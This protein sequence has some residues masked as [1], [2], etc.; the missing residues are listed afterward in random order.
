MRIS[1]VIPVYNGKKYLLAAVNSVIKQTL[2][3]IELIIVDDGS[4]DGFEHEIK[5]VKTDFPLRIL[6][7]E[8]GGQSSARNHGI[9]EA[10]GDFIAL[11]DQDDIW[12]SQHLEKL[13]EPFHNNPDLGWVYSNVDNSRRT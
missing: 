10:K 12:C 5:D 4:T 13:A 11:L 7:K 8:N 6:K 1:V 2:Q 3:P 9:K